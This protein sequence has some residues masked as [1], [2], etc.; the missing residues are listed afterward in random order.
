MLKMNA[1]KWQVGN[2]QTHDRRYILK[3]TIPPGNLKKDQTHTPNIARIC[4]GFAV[5]SFRGHVPR[6]THDGIIHNGGIII[7]IA[8]NGWSSF[9]DYTKVGKLDPSRGGYEDIGGLLECRE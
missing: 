9:G 5:Q 3:G 4:V 1:T 8:V 2:I 7:I 6:R